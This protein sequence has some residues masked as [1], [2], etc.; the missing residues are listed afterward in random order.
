MQTGRFSMS[1][2]AVI[3][4]G[5]LG[6]A[7][8]VHATASDAALA[9]QPE[10]P[11]GG[12]GAAVALFQPRFEPTAPQRPQQA[13]AVVGA[14]WGTSFARAS[15]GVTFWWFMS[16][17]P[18]EW[19]LIGTVGG[20]VPRSG[21]RFGEAIAAY[22]EPASGNSCTVAIGSPAHRRTALS[23]AQ[24]MGRVDVLAIANA[25]DPLNGTWLPVL[26][27][28]QLDGDRLGS[29][30]AFADP[31]SGPVLLASAPGRNL[32]DAQDA[33]IVWVCSVSSEQATRT[34][35]LS[36]PEPRPGDRL[37]EELA[38]TGTHVF[39]SLRRE[40]G[41]V[42]VFTLD[43]TL[44]APQLAT[45][46]SAPFKGLAGFGRSLAADGGVVA[47]G[48]PG[49]LDDEPD[50]GAVCIYRGSAPHDVL[51]VIA[52]PVPGECAGFGSSIAIRGDRLVIGT[53][54]GSDSLSGG[55][56]FVY[57]LTSI[58]QAAVLEEVITGP[59]GPGF[60][61]SLAVTP[62]HVLIG[63]PALGGVDAPTGGAL[64]RSLDESFRSPDI[65]GDG[66]VNGADLGAL[67]MRFGLP[68]SGPTQ[69][70]APADLNN[71]GF[72][73]GVDLG[74]LLSAWG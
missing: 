66:V 15:G 6:T 8:C 26:P 47:I 69:P 10:M 62:S 12:A 13:L 24:S 48:A 2:M 57:R 51:Q 14:P 5:G 30:V 42:A 52:S 1:L 45:T 3:A 63:A 74:I 67:L 7:V 34:A 64:A 58:D 56:V 72:I 16:P 68:C 53:A 21:A 38:A 49:D 36:V 31:G 39:A 27:E 9:P 43:D 37:G 71:D 33:G 11:L 23:V 28:D 73:N 17:G 70:C 46:L 20:P 19:Q 41:Q 60:A 54:Q 32:G 44:S 50:A 25:A 22:Q 4:V 65:N 61:A 55:K 59:E 18:N 35:F 40:A 29:A